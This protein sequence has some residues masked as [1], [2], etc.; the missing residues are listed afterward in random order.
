MNYVGG[1]KLLK[2]ATMNL[3]NF[4]LPIFV[5]KWSIASFDCR[6]TDRLPSRLRCAAASSHRFPMPKFRMLYEML[7]ADEV[8]TQQQVHSPERPPKNG[9]NRFIPQTTFRPIV[10]EPLIRRH[11][12]EWITLES[13]PCQSN[14]CGCW[15]H[16][17]YR[18]ACTT[19]WVS[20][21]Y[22]WRNSSCLP[23]LWFGVL[24]F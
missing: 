2:E 5:L 19:V 22:G 12:A 17:S 7:L 13:C 18:Q 6:F 15:W 16:H 4:Y 11:N 23:Q 21:Q 10:K 24:H 8:I 14:L 1:S 9:L 3:F 20:V